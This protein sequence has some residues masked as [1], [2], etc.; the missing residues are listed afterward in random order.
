MKQFKVLILVCLFFYSGCEKDKSKNPT[1]PSHGLSAETYL[2]LKIGATWT[3]TNTTT[4]QGNEFSETT[5][6]RIDRTEKIT[7]NNKTY[8]VS[9]E[10]DEEEGFLQIENNRIYSYSHGES[11]EVPIFNFEI[12]IGETWLIF[13]ER[14]RMG[15]M[16]LTGKFLG[17]ENLTV[18]AGTFTGCAMFEHA[19]KLNLFNSAG[20]VEETEESTEV[21]WLAPDVGLAKS[22]EEEKKDGKVTGTLMEQ[23]VNYN[24]PE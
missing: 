2:P 4:E 12:E 8:F 20:K 15:S 22:T 18:P 16:T 11:Q 24:I 21:I 1:P 17:T 5:T 7:Q 23:L 6:T 14:N 13:D 10:R 19:F 3:Y 9:V